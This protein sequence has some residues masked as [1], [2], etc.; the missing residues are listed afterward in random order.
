MSNM[1]KQRAN[2]RR[3]RKLGWILSK[4]RIV[5]GIVRM[6]AMSRRSVRRYIKPNAMVAAGEVRLTSNDGRWFFT[7][8]VA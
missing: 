7:L 4:V 2:V 6:S 1:I 8:D 5:S 3:R